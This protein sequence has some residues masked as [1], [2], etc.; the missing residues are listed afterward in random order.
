V[1]IL[2]VRRHAERATVPGTSAL[3][4]GGRAMAGSLSGTKYALVVASPLPRAQET[5]RLIGGG[6]DGTEPSLLPD[7]GGANLFGPTETLVAWARLLADRDELR[8]FADE[9]LAAW[10]A[11]A[12][13]VGPRDRILAISHG[14]IIDL[15]AV[16]L[17]S[18]L[19]LALAGPS[20][21]Y[22][23]GVRVTYTKG[24]PV[25]LELLRVR[26]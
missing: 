18:S 17:G 13:R 8:V 20:F 19:G 6:L 22:C 4:A 23:E 25:R 11:I 16:A 21:G 10:S 12:R 24:A 5:A 15:P 14:G 9:Q 26:G 1:P 2:E 3:S 7:I